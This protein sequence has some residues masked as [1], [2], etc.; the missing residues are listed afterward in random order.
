MK[1]KPQH[2]RNILLYRGGDFVFDEK[3]TVFRLQ[4]EADGKVATTPWE[5]WEWHVATTDVGKMNLVV[6]WV[7][8]SKQHNKKLEHKHNKE[9][10]EI[11]NSFNVWEWLTTFRSYD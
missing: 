6:A 2:Q 3:A 11:N 10:F 9:P 8:D 4:P 7:K 5:M 1:V